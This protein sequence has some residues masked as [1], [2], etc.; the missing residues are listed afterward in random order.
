MKIETRAVRAGLEVDG[1][2]GAVTPPIH[3]ATTF[4]RDPDGSYPR[5]FLY[6]RIDNPNR[7][8]LEVAMAEL[9]GG[10]AAAAFSS[11]TAAAAA[12]FTA[13]APGDHVLAPTDVY[14]GTAALLRGQMSGWGLDVEFVDMSD[15]GAVEAALRPGTRLV[16]TETPSNPL[17][18]ITDLGAVAALAH[19]VGAACVCDS[20]W[21]TPVL[22]RPLELGCDL[23]VHASTKYLGGH[24]DVQGGVVVARSGEGLFER[25]RGVQVNGGAV[26]SP[27]DSWLVRRGLRTL[28]LRM[29]AHS[30]GAAAVAR[31]LAGHNKV[32]A[33]HYPGLAGHPGHEIAARQMS[34]F[35]GM[36]SLQVAGGAGAAMAVAARARLFTRAT[37]L[38]GTESLIEHRASMEGEGTATP[39]DLLR[40]SIG[41][42]H[43]DDLIDDLRAALDAAH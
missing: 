8:A 27:F 6:A 26:A 19:S 35:G 16:W 20:T 28:P 9:E 41:L 10:A 40:L 25:V 3:L 24:G 36:V 38:G 18:R 14:H 7:R 30:D 42:E 23:V 2:T 17:L 11:G 21:A 32:E 5:E 34:G 37:S 12:V 29:R 43:P 33:V 39:D 1:D 15:V 4:E 22:Q 31:F 13:L